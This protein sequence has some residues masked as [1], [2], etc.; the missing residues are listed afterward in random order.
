ML[1]RHTIIALLLIL[2][3]ACLFLWWQAVPPLGGSTLERQTRDLLEFP[4][5]DKT[6]YA[7]EYIWALPAHLFLTLALVLLARRKTD[8]AP[9][10][11][12]KPSVIFSPSPVKFAVF[13]GLVSLLAINIIRHEIL[14]D[15]YLTD[16]EWAYI[17]Q[18]RT[19]STGRL[20]VPP[21][22]IRTHF[23]YFFLTM[24][25]DKWFSYLLPGLSLLMTPGVVLFDLPFLTIS[26]LNALFIPTF[27][28]FARTLL[29]E[30]AARPAALL[31]LIS[32]WYLLLSATIEPYMPF[33]LLM[34]I[35]FLLLLRIWRPL[36]ANPELPWQTVWS[37]A[38]GLGITQGSMLLLRGLEFAIMGLALCTFFV[39]VLV[40]RKIKFSVAAPLCLP[41]L[42]GMMPFVA[43]LLYY[44]YALTGDCFTVPMIAHKQVIVYGFGSHVYNDHSLL[45]GLTI[46]GGNFIRMTCWL[47][48]TPLSMAPIL[49]MCFLRKS[50]PEHYRKYGVLLLFSSI[51]FVFLIPYS[52]SGVSEMGPVYL[53][54][55]APIVLIITVGVAQATVPIIARKFNRQPV[56][57]LAF[58]RCGIIGGIIVSLTTFS[59]YHFVQASIIA[60][61]VAL[62]YQLFEQSTPVAKQDDPPSGGHVV[63]VE[64]L[65]P[66]PTA[67]VLGI[68]IP[69]PDLTEPV[70][71]LNGF[72]SEETEKQLKRIFPNRQFHKQV[73]RY[74][75][76]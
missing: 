72:P 67:Y 74:H 11:N 39:W 56:E 9:A 41:F 17:F 36:S 71:Y 50:A 76:R 64:R 62:P 37:A 51:F 29:N 59:L 30:Q 42:L 34:L 65:F 73:F 27:Y 48:G 58:W 40:K 69:D 13:T 43:F 75:T 47:L 14:G 19:F 70:L 35:W 25:G 26:I 2:A 68:R 46:W 31:F 28:W 3:T 54:A 63:F 18:A 1:R 22:E 33:A 12:Q 32:P 66:A 61:N 4:D 8:R 5:I 20:Y 45:K 49:G 7:A 10:G 6:F 24:Q 15:G 60:A 23:N 52:M 16:D 38:L 55:I 57:I 21:P 44:Q 53:F